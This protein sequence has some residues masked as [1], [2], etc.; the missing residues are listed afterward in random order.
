MPY[1]VLTIALNVTRGKAIEALLQYALHVARASLQEPEQASKLR[2]R[3]EDKVRDKLTEKLDKRV[4]PSLA[5]HSLFGKYLPNL[6]YLDKEWLNS[7][8]ERIFPR[9]PEMTDYW[10]AAWDG[11]MFR[12]DFFG[13]LY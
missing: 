2:S 7:S 11:Y 8:L 12:G 4:D 6:H 1:D 13:R 3:M 10:K 5:V 9:R